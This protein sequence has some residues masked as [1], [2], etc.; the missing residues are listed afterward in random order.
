M[1]RISP[2]E[3]K[4]SPKKAK[5]FKAMKVDRM[6][7]CKKLKLSKTSP[8]KKHGPKTMTIQKRSK[9]QVVELL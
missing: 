9:T 8:T 5:S 7:I 1:T 4:A 6:S 3:T 2:K